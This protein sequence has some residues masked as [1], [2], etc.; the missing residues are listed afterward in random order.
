ML[1]KAIIIGRLVADPEHRMTQ[2]GKGVANLRVAVDRK[3]RE[4]ETDFFDVTAWGQS[5][6][7]ACTYLSKGRLVAIE[8]RI[9]VRQYTDKDNAQ[10]KVWE[11]VA[12]SIQPLD[13]G[14]SK[15]DGGQPQPKRQS[16]PA[17]SVED[18]EDPF[19]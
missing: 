13:S 4:K 7:F 6:D 9:Q 8:G 3:G 15:E 19:A 10:R 5:A 17:T 18:I 12:D 11:I 2:S 1:N 14:K 16:A